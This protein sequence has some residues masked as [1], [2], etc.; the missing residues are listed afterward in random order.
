MF[1]IVHFKSFCQY[2][3]FTFNRVVIMFYSALLHDTAD[4][5]SCVQLVL[6]RGALITVCVAI[7]IAGIICQQQ[8]TPDDIKGDGN[9]FTSTSM[10]DMD[11]KT[12][13]L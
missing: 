6:R 11:N 7:L 12:T 2:S 1:I 13:V 4:D 10:P 8:Y 3:N 9:K 5:L